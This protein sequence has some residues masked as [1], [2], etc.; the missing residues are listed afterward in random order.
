MGTDQILPLEAALRYANSSPANLVIVGIP[1]RIA[2]RG[3]ALRCYDNVDYLIHENINDYNIS[4]ALL[5]EFR[6]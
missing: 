1:A 6:T 2:A 5:Y 4:A 3:S